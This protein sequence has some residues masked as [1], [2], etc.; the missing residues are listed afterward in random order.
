LFRRLADHRVSPAMSII[1]QSGNLLHCCFSHFQNRGRIMELRCID[2]KLLPGL[3][4]QSLCDKSTDEPLHLLRRRLL[5]KSSFNSSNIYTRRRCEV[6]PRWW[7]FSRVS[8]LSPPFR[9]VHYCPPLVT[10]LGTQKTGNMHAPRRITMPY[11]GYCF[12]R[13][14]HS[15]N[16]RCQLVIVRHW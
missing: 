7:L 10:E 8:F 11:P 3:A 14:I 1:H 5:L 15:R 12:T 6:V 9:T 16:I 13:S 4:W 2:R